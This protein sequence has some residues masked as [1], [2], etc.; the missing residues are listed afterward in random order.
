MSQNCPAKGHFS[1]KNTK[2]ADLFEDSQAPLSVYR[3]FNQ[4]LTHLYE[5]DIDLLNR[6][7]AFLTECSL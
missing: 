4:K 3:D 6:A 5:N 1:A 7:Y 2:N